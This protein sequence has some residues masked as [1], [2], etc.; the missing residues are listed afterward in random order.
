MTAKLSPAE[1]RDRR[2][3]RAAARYI[4]QVKSQPQKLPCLRVPGTGAGQ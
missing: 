4:A 2:Q 3:K 1:K